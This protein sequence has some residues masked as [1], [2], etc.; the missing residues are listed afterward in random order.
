MILR[1][2]VYPETGCAAYVFGHKA[3]TVVDAHDDDRARF[4]EWSS[5]LSRAR[6]S[7][8]SSTRS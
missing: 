6:R 7:R 2:F 5:P 1:Q 8:G 3:S 4:Q